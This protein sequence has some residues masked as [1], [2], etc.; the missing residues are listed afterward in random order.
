MFN[1]PDLCQAAPSQQSRIIS[2]GNVFDNS[3]KKHIHTA[4][5]AIWH[6]KEEAFTCLRYS[7]SIGIAILT[8]MMTGYTW[9]NPYFAPAVFWFIDSTKSCLILKHEPD[10]VILTALVCIMSELLDFYVN[11]FEVSM[12]SSLAFWGCLL[13]GITFRHPCR[14]KT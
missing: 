2:L 8:N 13:R 11:F 7:R 9:S 4:G 3:A 1:P 5:I 12:T 6:N 10:T 14:C